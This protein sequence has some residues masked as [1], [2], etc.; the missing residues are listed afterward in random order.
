MP[1]GLRGTSFTMQTLDPL[2]P[3]PPITRPLTARP[4]NGH[5]PAPLHGRLEGALAAADN[6]AL[7]DCSADSASG[8]RD[9]LL[10]MLLLHDVWR[11]PLDRLDG[12][13]RFQSEPAA[14]LLKVQLERRLL[15]RVR[16]GSATQRIATVDG[17]DGMRQVAALDLVPSVYRWLESEASWDELVGFL[18]VEGGP[19]ADFDDFVATA[20]VGLRGDVKLV[21]AENYWDEMGRGRPADVHTQLHNDLV[22]AVDMPRLGRLE[23]PVPALERLAIGGVLVTNRHLQPELIGALGLLEIQAGPRCRAVVRALRRLQAPDDALAFYQEHAKV[24]PHHGKA[25]LERAIRPLSADRE[26]ARRIVDGAV[27]RH[28]VNAR[29][30]NHMSA[31]RNEAIV[32]RRRAGAIRG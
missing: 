7:I 9:E 22:R 25:W 32:S 4:I 10:S 23:L 16:C 12:R 19:D 13:E 26:W 14:L 15:E 5:P 6:E 27:W 2:D 8:E 31:R 1:D 20:Q 24:D 3:R 18:A 17:V 21:L 30:F 28:H 29:F 11:A